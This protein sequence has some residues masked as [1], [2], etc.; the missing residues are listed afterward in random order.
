MEM[1]L[2]G[3]LNLNKPYGIASFQLIEILRRRFRL[4]KIGY[5]GTLD[6]LATGVLLLCIGKATRL[7]PFLLDCQKRYHALIRLGI[8]TQ[9][10]DREGKITRIYCKSGY[11]STDKV[12]QVIKGFKGE[13]E[14]VPPMF[15]ALR[16]RGRR[17]Y[18]LA[19]NCEE[20]PRNPRK[21]RIDEITCFAYNYPFLHIDVLCSKGTYIRTLAADIGTHL[22]QGAHLWALKRVSIGKYNIEDAIS[23]ENIMDM[24]CKKIGNVVIPNGEI[25]SFL[26]SVTLDSKQKEAMLNGHRFTIDH[27]SFRG[28]ILPEKTMKLRAYD[29]EGEFLGLGEILSRAGNNMDSDIHIMPFLVLA[30]NKRPCVS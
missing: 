11:P 15:S 29:R 30:S 27:F 14:Q 26:P 17:L 23:W 1:P 18:E 4:K 6:P 25:L 10:Q 3:L 5:A 19:R 2:S 7:V 22:G 28:E 8:E 12:R 9:T 16:Y 21:V 24:D 20:A 13:I